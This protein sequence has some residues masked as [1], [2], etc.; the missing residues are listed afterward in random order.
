MILY[1]LKL[2][3]IDKKRVQLADYLYLFK[4]VVT[5]CNIFYISVNYVFITP[6][7]SDNCF[8]DVKSIFILYKNIR[9][10]IDFLYCEMALNNVIA[11]DQIF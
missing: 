5:V 11:N 8:I 9:N 2:H 7:Y 1:Y 6:A 4:N 3:T 10:C